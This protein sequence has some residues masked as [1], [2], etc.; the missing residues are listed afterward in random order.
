MP[1]GGQINSLPSAAIRRTTPVMSAKTAANGKVFPAANGKV[2]LKVLL[3]GCMLHF[4]MILTDNGKEFT[5]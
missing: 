2:F 4:Q 3:T 1:E 5:A